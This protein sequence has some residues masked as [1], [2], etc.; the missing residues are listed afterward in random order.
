MRSVDRRGWIVRTLG[1][2]ERLE[3]CL[4][5][6][7]RGESRP[8]SLRNLRALRRLWRFESH[9]E[10]EQVRAIGRLEPVILSLFSRQ[11]VEAGPY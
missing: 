9:Q 7:M 1:D 2:F 4:D 10:T 6:R 3:A 5:G 8:P 11:G